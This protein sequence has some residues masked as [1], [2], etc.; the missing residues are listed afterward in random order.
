MVFCLLAAARGLQAQQQVLALPPAYSVAPPAVQE[1]ET[2][3]PGAPQM[4]SFAAGVAGVETPLWLQWG[5]VTT[6]PHFL[7]RFLYG[8][9]IQSS[10]GQSQKTV[11]QQFSPGVLFALGAH[12]T[13]D[14]TPLLSFY[15]SSAFKNTVDE[16]VVLSWGTSYEDWTFGFSQGYSATTDPSI[17]TGT[18]TEMESY[19]TS[20]KASHRLNSA[21]SVDLS[22]NQ[23]FSF[24]QQFTSTRSWSTLNWLNY[25]AGEKWDT[26]LGLGY[27]YDDVNP[28]PNVMDETVQAR[29]RWQLTQKLGFNLHGGL[30][31]QQYLG[32]GVPALFTPIF[33][34]SVQYHPFTTTSLSL[35]GDRSVSP[36]LFQGQVSDT[37][38]VG[39]TL[40]Q[41][42]LQRLSLS[43]GGSY[44]RTSYLASTN[45]LSAVS[46]RTDNYYAFTARLI[47][48]VLD[49]GSAAIFYQYSD[50]P[51]TIQ[52]FSFSSSQVGLELQYRF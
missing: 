6:H 24:A 15:S 20:L 12:W 1:N 39:V 27:E 28:G 5:P 19:T 34:A 7:Y 17:V 22:V 33:G 48:A 51:S 42:L 13:L 38:S 4:E 10:P 2:N 11:V 16:N 36:S 37:T 8:T 26:G 3:Q 23:N 29:V 35:T 31:V 44:G 21:I 46:G 41:Q 50:N 43:V 49:R 30:E 18:Q 45:S 47:T 52:A 25:S 40:T 32:G 9:G 14:Y